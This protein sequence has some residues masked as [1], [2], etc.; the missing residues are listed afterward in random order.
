[1]AS[2]RQADVYR[3]V[4]SDLFGKAYAKVTDEDCD[5]IKKLIVQ[6]DDRETVPN[7]MS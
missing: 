2:L 4:A 6:M 1:M 7:A 5:R 3:K